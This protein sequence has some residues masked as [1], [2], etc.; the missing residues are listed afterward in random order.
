MFIAG[1]F[2]IARNRNTCLLTYVS[3]LK[4]W[5]IYTMECCSAIENKDMTNF[6]G[7]C[8]EPENILLSEVIQTEN[9]RH[10]A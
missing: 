7:Q 4:T 10:A 1:L 8:G 2:I 9:D 5:F 6:A 3:I